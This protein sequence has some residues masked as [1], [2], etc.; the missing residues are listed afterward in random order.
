MTV[1]IVRMESTITERFRDDGI[2][3]NS[4]KPAVIY[5]NAVH[6][7]DVLE[8][9]AMVQLQKLVSPNGWDISWSDS[10]YK[11]VHYHPNTH[12][13]L[14]CFRSWAILELGGRRFGKEFMI[15][16]GDVVII[17]AGVGHRRVESTPNFKVFGL[18]PTRFTYET[19]WAYEKFR[20]S[21]MGKLKWVPMPP[22]DPVYGKKGHL[23]R[24]WGH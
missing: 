11:R 9:E 8:K 4:D 1:Q 17:P 14:V 19:Y 20:R 6:F 23:L 24:M 16:M 21:A 15:R 7:N 2:V 22:A 18:Y 3:P 12:E 13:V 10:V 5:R